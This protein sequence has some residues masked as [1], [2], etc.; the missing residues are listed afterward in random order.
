LRD[1]Q[2]RQLRREEPLQPTDTSQLLD[3]LGDARFES[4]V[5]LRYLLGAL[6]QFVQQPRVLD[7]DYRLRREI[8]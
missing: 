6:T 8:F 4:A 7:R 3:L 5:Q 1:D 2:L